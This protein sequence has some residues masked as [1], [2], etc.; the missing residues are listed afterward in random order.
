MRA[1]ASWTSCVTASMNST[2]AARLPSGSTRMRDATELGRSVIRPVASAARSVVA[3]LEIFG[4][5][6]P[7]AGPRPPWM[8]RE[9]STFRS[10]N[11]RST[12]SLKTAS[13]GVIGARREELAV[14]HLR[15]VVLRTVDAE[16]PLEIGV[17]RGE[18][19]VR[20]GPVGAVSVAARGLEF[21]VGEARRDGVPH[22]RAAADA[23][24]PD[25]AERLP[26]G[27]RV[28]V[29]VVVDEEIRVCRPVRR[30]S[31][32]DVLPMADEVAVEE[33][34]AVRE[35][36]TVVTRAG[37]RAPCLE[38]QD[39][40]SPLGQLAR[41][42]AAGRAGAYDDRVPRFRLRDDLH[43]AAGSTTTAP[44][45]R[46]KRGISTGGPSPSRRTSPPRTEGRAPCRAPS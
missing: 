38:D 26:L 14:G 35:E 7:G 21:E 36:R 25:P 27:G 46:A 12:R 23:A 30:V 8:P 6:S 33:A 1:R 20:D 39:T 19:G 4:T 31:F 18:V 16:E 3:E 42:R 43:P 10:P 13:A 9:M 17:V 24:G 37:D 29:V 40:E 5:I 44:S 11:W 41:R 45:S 34:D 15:E 22:E 28:R 32:L 2:P